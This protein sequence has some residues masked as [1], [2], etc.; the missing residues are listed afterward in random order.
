MH[1]L[2]RSLPLAPRSVA[3]APA[4]AGGE[5]ARLRALYADVDAEPVAAEEEAEQ[6]RCCLGV[7]EWSLNGS[8]S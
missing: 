7:L 8:D 4:L 2:V 1:T 6:V 3:A 5:A